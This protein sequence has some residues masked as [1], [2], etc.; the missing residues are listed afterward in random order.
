MKRDSIFYQLFRQSPSLL[1]ELIPSPPD[2]AAAYCFD[3]VS[4]KEPRYE[5]DG[6][7]VP[8]EDGT[9]TI[10]F[11][12]VQMQRDE[13]LCERLFSEAFLYFYQKRALFDDWQVVFIY[14]S[15]SIEQRNLHPYRGL[16]A[17]SQVHRVY[18]NEL[19]DIAELPIW[20]SLMVL[21]IVSPDQA[22]TA[23]R[24]L[25]T[26][27][28]Q[29]ENEA[30][31]SRAIIDMVVTIISYKFEQLSRKDVETMLGITLKKTRLYQ[32][33]KEEG[34]EEGREEGRE[35]TAQGVLSLL[36]KRFNSIPEDVQATVAELPFS[37]LN[38]LMV[39]ALDFSSVADLRNWLQ[40]H[41]ENTDA[42]INHDNP[43]HDELS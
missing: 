27:A 10:F 31:T 28:K 15:R 17:L 4:V 21:T 33:I 23:A 24:E 11:C 32:E 1:F 42:P 25:L 39:S 12:E 38:A 16:L 36:I 6:V 37:R 30:Q 9:G 34:W 3:S 40:T 7:F 20:V 2:N 35:E 8:P 41:A 18:L 14:P 13:L 26:R 29:E 5:I 22:P 19:G 43:N